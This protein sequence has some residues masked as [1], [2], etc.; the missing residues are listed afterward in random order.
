[1]GTYEAPTV[2][3]LGSLDELTLTYIYKSAGSGDMIVIAGVA[4]PAEGGSFIS[5][6]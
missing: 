5:A 4:Q 2:T 1:M 6:S 3:E